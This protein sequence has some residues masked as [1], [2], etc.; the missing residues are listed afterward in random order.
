MSTKAQLME[1][2]AQL[3]GSVI[4]N[5]PDD[6]A[7]DPTIKNEKVRATNLMAWEIFRIF[8]DAMAQAHDSDN[9]R[10]PKEMADQIQNGFAGL[11]KEVSGN[12]A[13]KPVI[14]A[15]IG[16]AVGALT[17]GQQLPNPSP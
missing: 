2:A 9:W 6:L 11:L 3:A 14:E 7:V 15:L 12:A 8:Y 1:A 13:L 16:K 5:L 17:D 10:S 4:A